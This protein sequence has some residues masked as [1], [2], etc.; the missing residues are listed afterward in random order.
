MLKML[1]KASSGVTKLDDVAEPARREV[2]FIVHWLAC[3]TS[4]TQ[5]QPTLCD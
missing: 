4:G 1:V 2:L 3:L 5:P